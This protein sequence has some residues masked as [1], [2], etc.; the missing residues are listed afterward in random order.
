[1][2]WLALATNDHFS[3]ENGKVALTAYIRK[4]AV[5][6][7]EDPGQMHGVIKGWG[8][9]RSGLSL[10]GILVRVRERGGGNVV[11]QFQVEAVWT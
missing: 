3:R 1:M 11:S 6:Q 9:D 5:P 4:L 10:A 7:R 2:P 8:L